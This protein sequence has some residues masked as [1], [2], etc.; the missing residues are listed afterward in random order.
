MAADSQ[1]SMSDPDS[2]LQNDPH[3]DVHSDLHWVELP[4]GSFV[5]GTDSGGTHPEDG[6][7]PSHEVVLKPF[8]LSATTVTNG[9][10]AA[11]VQDTG[12]VSEAE[13]FGW[14]FVF[15]GFLPDDHPPT[16][17]VQ[18]APWWRQVYGATWRKPDGPDSSVD[19]RG[20]HPVVHVSWNDAQAF[21]HWAGARLPTEAEW[22][23]GARG[24]LEGKV[25]PWGDEKEPDGRFLMNVFHGDFPAV[26]AADDGWPGT[27]PVKSFPPNGFGLYEATGNVWE[28]CADWF[29]ADYYTSCAAKGSTA[30]PQGPDSGDAR[31]TRGGSY[32]CHE[33]YCRRYR[34]DARNSMAPDS[35]TGNTGFR[36]ARDIP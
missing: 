29:R 15:G 24:G 9:Q 5:M 19:D 14:S 3:G 36:L 1:R 27:A 35:T 31:V 23:Y 25:F 20:D 12:Y 33:S 30:D 32:L 8:A 10:F 16:R 18:S 34:V 26:N 6:A 11:F 28:W 7:Y 2:G 22:E 4:G 21:S 17:A 13:Q